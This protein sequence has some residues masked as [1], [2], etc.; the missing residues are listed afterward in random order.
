MTIWMAVSP[1]TD[2]RNKD[3]LRNCPKG[4]GTGGRELL[5]SGQAPRAEVASGA[6]LWTEL[7]AADW[8]PGYLQGACPVGAARPGWG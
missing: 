5:V 4:L 1:R 2:T 8:D 6:G 3:Y 7:G